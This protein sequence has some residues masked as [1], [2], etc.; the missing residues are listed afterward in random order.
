[1]EKRFTTPGPVLNEQGHPIAG[2]ASSGILQYNRARI[3]APFY[4]IKEW[5]WYQVN[6]DHL[7]LQFTFGHASYAGQIGVTLFNFK[8]GEKIF[9][10]DKILALPFSS[11]KLSASADADGVLL[12]DKKDMK[13]RLETRGDTRFLYCKCNGLEAEITLTRLTPQA[14]AINIPFNEYPTA[15][16]YNH[17]INCMKALG[18]V[19]ANGV[20]YVFDENAWGLL[21]WGRGVW[22]F[23]NA[24]YWSNAAGYLNGQ[25]FGFNLG[26]G[27]GNTSAATENCIFYKGEIHKL[28]AVRF[29]LGESYD[30]PWNL[31]DEE[32]RLHLTLA[33][34]Y[35]RETAIKL[36][37]VNNNTHQMFGAFS[38]FAVLNDGTKLDVHD[39]IGFAEHAVNNW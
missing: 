29:E 21:D 24:W 28:G 23:H 22:P 10:Q 5:D 14:L 11:L 37:W 20:E 6:N 38:G 3:K 18:R 25:V 13:M 7:A 17:K 16:Y 27:F 35:D 15:F 2:W 33:P 34:T 26:C 19:V 36:L 1:M 8:T 12:Y 30:A 9:T 4:R 39:I 32:G 31:V